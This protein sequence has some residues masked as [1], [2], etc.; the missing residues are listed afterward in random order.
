MRHKAK[1]ESEM[2][3]DAELLEALRYSQRRSEKALFWFMGAFT[4]FALMFWGSFFWL[5]S[6]F[7]KK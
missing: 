1:E 3:D 7:L 6:E 4:C 5:L 2:A